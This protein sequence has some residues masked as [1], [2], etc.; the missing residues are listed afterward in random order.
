MCL[1]LETKTLPGVST[2][3][4]ITITQVARIPSSVACK[5]GM[6]YNYCYMSQRNSTTYETKIH[7]RYFGPDPSALARDLAFR[8]TV[9]IS[10]VNVATRYSLC[11]SDMAHGTILLDKTLRCMSHRDGWNVSPISCVRLALF[12]REL[13][14]VALLRRAS[15]P[16]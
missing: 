1:A 13:R 12:A 8:T 9:T 2:K 3:L 7:A 11:S 10:A 14:G 4:A 16:L 5:G 6:D 15:C